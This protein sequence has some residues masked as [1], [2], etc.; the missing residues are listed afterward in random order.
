MIDLHT[1]TTASDGSLS[2]CELIDYAIKKN[3]TAMAITDHDTLKGLSQAETYLKSLDS[4]LILIKGIEFSCSMPQYNFDIHIL[5]YMIDPNNQVFTKELKRIVEDRLSRNNKMI[6]K[7][8]QL[9]YPITLK[10]IKA[11][12][13]DSVITRAHIAKVLVKKG[14]FKN[15]HQVFQDLIGNDRPAYVRRS[16]VDASL[17]IKLINKTGGISVLAH[18]TLYNLKQNQLYGLLSLLKDLGLQG[19]E[20]YYSLYDSKQHKSMR[21]LASKFDLIETGGSDYHGDNKPNLDLGN[22]YGNFQVPD[23]ILKNLIK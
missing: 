20:S 4:S 22:G 16:Q 17:V 14:Y 12:A 3:L 19:I 5:G 7:I 8:N 15:N 2:P 18:P 1:H 11:Y 10:E 9:G 13:G 21:N 6:A 23:S